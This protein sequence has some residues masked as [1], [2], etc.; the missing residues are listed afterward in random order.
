MI[1]SGA[2][3]SVNADTITKSDKGASQWLSDGPFVSYMQDTSWRGGLSVRRYVRRSV[4]RSVHTS[5][6]RSARPSAGHVY[7]L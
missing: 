6:R 4:R 3:R 2:I 1:I 5:V 7:T